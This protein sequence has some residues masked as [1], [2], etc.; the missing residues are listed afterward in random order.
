LVANQSAEF[1]L[2]LQI[3]DVATSI[4]VSG[5]VIG[6]DTQTANQSRTLNEPAVL[7]LPV[8]TRSPFEF[9]NTMA[10]VTSVTRTL[11]AASTRAQNYARFAFNGGRDMTGL[12]LVDGA[13]ATVGDWA[14]CSPRL[15]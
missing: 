13:S 1:D 12:V 6:L 3:G 10:G 2:R 14:A 15:T 11:A 7:D 9:V 4:E 8:S 5:S